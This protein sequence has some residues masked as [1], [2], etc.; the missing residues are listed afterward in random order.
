[1]PEGLE[2][3][4]GG[5]AGIG[6]IASLYGGLRP[7]EDAEELYRLAGKIVCVEQEVANKVEM[8]VA[9]R[10]NERDR[11]ASARIPGDIRPRARDVRPAMLLPGQ[12][13]VPADI[14]DNRARMGEKVDYLKYY[15]RRMAAGRQGEVG[16]DKFAGYIAESDRNR[17]TV[18]HSTVVRNGGVLTNVREGRE[19]SRADL[20]GFLEQTYLS[21][22]A[23]DR[24]CEYM[25]LDDYA[26]Y[27]RQRREERNQA[28]GRRPGRKRGSGA[29][30]QGAR[31]ASP[32]RGAPPRAGA[33][34][35]RGRRRGS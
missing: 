13:G 21:L 1:M 18:A 35:Q 23:I 30:R 6:E 34:G 2:M 22:R 17:D 16:D 10:R 19:C 32:G 25:G 4:Q 12:D 29:R 14:P 33:T 31:A 15:W 26:G 20:V 7:G 3:G 9:S 11:Y 24:L 27:V 8:C 28:K 5:L